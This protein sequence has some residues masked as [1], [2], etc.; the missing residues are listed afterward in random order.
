MLELIG[1]ILLGLLAIEALAWLAVGLVA[2]AWRW[3]IAPPLRASLA[4]YRWLY[5]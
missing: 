5:P 1:W 3:L 2:A 4:L